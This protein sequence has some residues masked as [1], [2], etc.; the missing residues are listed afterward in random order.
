M[1]VCPFTFEPLKKGEIMY[2]YACNSQMVKETL[3]IQVLTACGK[4]AASCLS[5]LKPRAAQAGAT[6]S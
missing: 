4:E 2:E 5:V 1:L 3:S 6:A